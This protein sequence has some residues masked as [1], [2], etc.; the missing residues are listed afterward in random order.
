MNAL[1]SNTTGGSNT[2]NG[3]Y[4]LVFNIT[5]NSNTALGNYAGSSITTG[6]SNIAIGYNSQVASATGSNQL[7]IGNWIYG[8]SGNIGIGTSTPWSKLDVVGTGSFATLRLTD[9]QTDTLR[10]RS[11]QS[12]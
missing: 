7:S 5:G 6:S 3:Y 1:A 4:A 9:V 11:Y 12:R 8:T 2:A 10:P